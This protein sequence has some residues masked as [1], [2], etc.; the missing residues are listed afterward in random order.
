MRSIPDWLVRFSVFVNVSFGGAAGWS[1]C[2]RFYKGRLDGS[3]IYTHLVSVTDKIF[4]FDPEHCR[5]AYLLRMY[6][7][8]NN[9]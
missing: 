6:G 8:Q 5:K 3:V 4:W 7:E 9:G 1:M 2:A